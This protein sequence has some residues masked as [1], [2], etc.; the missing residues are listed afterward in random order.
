MWQ[1]DFRNDVMQGWA[2]YRSFFEMAAQ[3]STTAGKVQQVQWV[4]ES[5]PLIATSGIYWFKASQLTLSLNFKLK[6]LSL[7]WEPPSNHVVL[8]CYQHRK[9]S[10]VSIKYSVPRLTP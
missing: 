5:I 1:L 8:L 3:A 10:N 7:G 9:F 6:L 2:V 4:A